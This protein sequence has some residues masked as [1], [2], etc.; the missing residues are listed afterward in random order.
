MSV[1]L[2]GTEGIK[3]KRTKADHGKENG[4]E[5]CNRVNNWHF[6]FQAVAI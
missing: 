6:E 4:L 5:I 1:A 3:I 2:A